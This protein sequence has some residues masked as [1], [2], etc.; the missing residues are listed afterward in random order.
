[1]Q[2]FSLLYQHGSILPPTQSGSGGNDIPIHKRE[3]RTHHHHMHLLYLHTC[4]PFLRPKWIT[5]LLH[6]QS[7]LH[8]HLLL[9]LLHT[10]ENTPTTHNTHLID[11]HPTQI[12]I[13]SPPFPPLSF[14][15]I[16]QS[17]LGCHNMHH[18]LPIIQQY[19]SAIRTPLR[20]AIPK[21]TLVLF[22]LLDILGD[23]IG[24]RLI[25]RSGRS[26]DNDHK[27]GEGGARR[28]AQ[29]DDVGGLAHVGGVD[30]G[31]D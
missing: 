23:G 4:A 2:D 16:K 21:W 3:A 31:V 28:D 18:H 11:Q 15:I 22:K 20:N 13:F 6:I 19:P 27:V 9:L 12:H 30:D 17:R 8:C 26:A 1:M 24:N 10:T 29:C 25:L 14:H 7:F 5:L